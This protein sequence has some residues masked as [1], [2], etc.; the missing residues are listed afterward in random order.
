MSKKRPRW[1]VYAKDVQEAK[2]FEA[3]AKQLEM[4][5]PQLLRFGT[6]RLLNQALDAY[7]NSQGDTKD[8]N[9]ERDAGDS[10]QE[11]GPAGQELQP[12]VQPTESTDGEG[13]ES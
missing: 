6:I 5:V 2:A 9:T 4:S 7:L 11:S 10:T 1:R 12:V 3:A 8:D 13:A